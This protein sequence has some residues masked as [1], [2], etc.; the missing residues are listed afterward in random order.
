VSFVLEVVPC[1]RP[2]AKRDLFAQFEP[3]SAAWVVSDLQ[4]KWHLQKELLARF[5]V[6][7]QSCVLR[8][9]E[10][11]KH[12]AFQLRPDLRLLSPELA[13]T[14]IWNWIEPLRLPWAKSP[15]AVPVILKQMQMWMSLLSDPRHQEVMPEWFAANPEAYVRWGHWFELCAQIWQRCSDENLVMVNWLPAIL[16]NED[17]S[18]LQ[19][20]RALTFDLGAQISQVEGQ[21]VR[22]LARLFDVKLIFPEAPWVALMQNTLRPY[23]DLLGEPYRGD[24]AWQPKVDASL[25]FGR[26]STA[27]AE[28]KD[29]LANVRRWLDAGV[30]PAAIAVVAPDIEEYW[31]ALQ[32]Y[33]AQEGLPVSKPLT[34]RLGGFVEMAQWMASLRTGLSKVSAADLEVFLF[35]DQESPRLSCDE[36]RVLFTHVYDSYDLRRAEHLFTAQPE[37]LPA[38]QVL[39][40]AEFLAWSLKF[41][42][43]RAEASRLTA[44]LQVVGQEVPP[45]LALLPA[46]WLSYLEGILARRETTLLAGDETG[47]WCVALSSS[48]WIPA[49]HGVFL[50]LSEGALRQLDTSPVSAGEAQKIFAD[51]GY[52]VGTNDHQE[53]EFELLWFLNR[54]WSE[55]RLS[56]AGT[57]FAGRVLTPSKLWM[58]AA[59]SNDKLLEKPVAPMATRWDEIQRLP[60]AELAKL[61]EWSGPRV[62]A[63]ETGLARDVSTEVNSWSASLSERISASSLEKYWRCPFVYAA[64]RKLKLNDEPALDLD[65]DRRTRGSLLHALAEELSLEPLRF[66][67]TDEELAALVD[68]VREKESIRLGDERLW[69]AQRAQHVRLARYFLDFERAW[70]ERFPNTQTV[71]R[72]LAFQAYLDP[73]TGAVTA[74]PSAVTLAGRLDRV[75]R[76]SQGR[77]ALIDYK[78]S[79][80]SLRNWK[81]WLEGHEIQLA[82]YSL[83]L[84]E[85]LAGLEKGP[86]VAANYYVIKESDRRKGFHLR[87]ESSELYSSSDCH[88]N[89]IL[90]EEKKD[91]FAKLRAQ[92]GAAVSEIMA[93]HLNPKPENETQCA[94]CSWRSLCRAPHLA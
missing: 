40:V 51:T 11:W 61:R 39:G 10:L 29:A 49:T 68:E 83:L 27:L 3:S 72:E 46:Q 8:A 84:Q 32:M 19:W 73:T 60:L 34:A 35:A 48:D 23:D 30:A 37:I 79:A 38:D 87:D 67:R 18:R 1:A 21:L 85:G 54:E 47:I 82:L 36:F 24:V 16:L 13:Q 86:V 41:W 92:I 45:E 89:F 53:L 80:G 70:R 14:L 15:Q 2:E 50:N 76:D 7:E 20:S 65:L 78:A 31:P 69:P 88:Y 26:F 90:E 74:E 12:F 6:L 93:G 81:S 17:L 42:H 62:V 28:V 77:Y 52:A 66:E 58:W 44:L 33:A 75:D 59:F 55:L 91:L 25:E 64:E 5:G 9:T 71:G 22:E 57:D 43:A 56:F 94:S 63:M 4:S